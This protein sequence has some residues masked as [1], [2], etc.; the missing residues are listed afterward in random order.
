MD[1]KTIC[2][3]PF[4]GEKEELRM[5]YVRFMAEARINIHHVLLT[6]AKK[7]PADGVDKTE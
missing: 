4:K 7:I 5:W 6:C 1:K 2:I 3:I